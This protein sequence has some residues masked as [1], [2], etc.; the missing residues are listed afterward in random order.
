MPDQDKFHIHIQTR[1]TTKMAATF[2]RISK[3]GGREVGWLFREVLEFY[4]NA[5][6]VRCEALKKARRLPPI[7]AAHYKQPKA[8]IQ[9]Q[10]AS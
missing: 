1:I 3:E 5:Q 8:E 10:M 4:F 2:D 7:P 9:Q 6:E